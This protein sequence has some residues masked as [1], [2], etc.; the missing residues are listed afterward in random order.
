MFSPETSLQHAAES[1]YFPRKIALRS[2]KTK[3]QYFYAFRAFAAHLGRVATLADLDDDVVTVWSVALLDQG[4]S[5]FTVREKV[6][7]VTA[8]WNWLAR[9][10]IVERFPTVEKIQAPVVQPVA[11]RED[12]LRRLFASA[13]KERG[14]IGGVP[15]DSWWV[16]HLAFLFCT[17]ERKS[18]ALSVRVEWLDLEHATCAIPANVR[19]GGRK[20]AIYHLWPELIELLKRSLAYAPE[21]ELVWPWDRCEVTYYHRWSRILADAGLPGGP[22]RKAHSLRCTAATMLAALGGDAARA[23][24]HSSPETTAKHYI[25]DRLMPPETHR[26]C[27]PW[28]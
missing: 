24:G 16:S 19:K 27:V 18:A 20:P 4:L 9:K 14:R 21:R 26:L 1:F 28:G 3:A 7:R 22:K 17:A 8:L 5:A 25:D 6:G 23:L 12:E 11:W 10:R 2:D 15:A 13:A